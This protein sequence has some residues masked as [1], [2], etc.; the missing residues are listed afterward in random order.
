M[1]EKNNAILEYLDNPRRFADVFNGFFGKGEMIIDPKYLREGSEK[2]DGSLAEN[3]DTGEKSEPIERI[4]DVKKIY[5]NGQ[6]LQI[7]CI[8]DQDY[9][10]YSSAIRT[11]TMDA[12][13]Y[14]KQLNALKEYH[15]EKKDLSGDEYAGKIAK[16]DKLNPVITL[17]WYHGKKQYDGPTCLK[18]SLKTF[19]NVLDDYVSDYSMNILYTEPDYNCDNFHTEFRE[20]YRTL[21]YRN[22]KI[23]LQK[24]FREDKA[25]RNIDRD[26]L[27]LITRYTNQEMIFENR[28]KIQNS[29]GGYDMFEAIEEWAADERAEGRA[30][31]RENARIEM[32]ENMLKDGR[33][34]EE[35]VSF[36]KLPEDFVRKVEKEMSVTV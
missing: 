30:E 10:D 12:M 3:P 8:E 27:D 6:I 25:F 24:M 11:L 13:E 18:D 21:S 34:V 15:R 28:E 35:I 4:R 2:L 20:L 19:G 17:W 33:T 23:S 5:E 29:Q 1:G 9:I 32:V 14:K 7:L 31:G 22:D 16:E 36:C 26:T